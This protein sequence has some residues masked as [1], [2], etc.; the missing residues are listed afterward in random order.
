MVIK[1]V[2]RTLT[3]KWNHIAIIIKESKDLSTLDFDK[4]LGYLMY[5]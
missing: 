1:K 5:H 4:L 3:S 2:L